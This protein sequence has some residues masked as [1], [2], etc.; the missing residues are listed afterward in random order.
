MATFTVTNTNDDGDGSLRQAVLDAN[1]AGGADRI[2]FALDP[3]SV[4]RL[5]QGE[6]AITDTLV[7]D[8]DLDDNGTPD[9]LIT[10][11]ANGDDVVDGA[12]ITDV[13][14]S[15]DDGRLDDNVRI[16]STTAE[17]SFTGLTLT[18]GR[19]TGSGL[20]ASGG[21]IS[22]GNGSYSDQTPVTV[23]DSVVSGN[24]TASFN[25][26]GGGIFVL[27]DELRVVNSTV[28][29]NVALGEG[30]GISGSTV[31]LIG[32]TV[33]DNVSSAQGLEGGGG[34][35]ASSI[36]LIDSTVSG[37]VSNGR[38]GGLNG[39]YVTATNT[40]IA[41]NSAGNNG[42]GIFTGGAI[43]LTN[44]TVTGNASLASRGGGGGTY[45]AYTTTIRNSIVLGNTTVD[46]FVGGEEA[47]TDG[48][49][50]T[51]TNSIVG[52]DA[53][54]FDTSAFPGVRNAAPSSVFA[55]TVETRA[56]EDRDGV[57][58]LATGVFGGRLGDNGGRVET[59]ALL[60]SDQNPAIDS[61]DDAAFD[62]P[63][64]TDARGQPRFVDQPGI[65]AEGG[66]GAGIIDLGA[67]E[68][69]GEPGSGPVIVPISEEGARTVAYIY[70]TLL[71]RDGEIDLEGLN[72]W[73]DALEGGL[74]GQEEPLTE[75]EMVE[76]FI[77]SDE[78]M[79]SFGDLDTLTNREIV[80]QLYENVL[81]RAG[82]A[83]GIDFWTGV[84][85]D[86]GLAA[87]EVLILF[88][89]ADENIAGLTF[90]ETLTEVSDGFWDFA[91]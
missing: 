32:S 24:S 18:G 27:I 83:A 80:E 33:S 14:A 42:G 90:V 71:N 49:A 88:A 3:G 44:S 16:F 13:A 51:I 36:D 69:D 46:T 73:I 58:E 53:E 77:G 5:V 15:L 8:G 78:F 9:I 38:G 40:T 57:A 4:I 10:G 89:T 70:E 26:D 76:F 82:D 79:A 2:E 62:L 43:E 63:V 37:N 75:I 19:G 54:A 85:D 1:A 87:A 55:E 23:T 30:G 91:A 50:L 61:G 25:A 41:G 60:G 35:R 22:G 52:A 59:V 34:V 7:I 12:G 21:A 47:A 68:F 74:D 29:G 20:A 81:D 65:G 39:G 17:T 84:L 64:P 28:S 11:D 86:S 66:A 67:L 31:T 72:F 45:S 48:S 56:D 6:I